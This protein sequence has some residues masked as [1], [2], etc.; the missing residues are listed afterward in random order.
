MFPI[1]VG[2]TCD[3]N[4]ET[5]A[6]IYAVVSRITE[7]VASTFL[8]AIKKTILLVSQFKWAPLYFMSNGEV[9]SSNASKAVFTHSFTVL[10]CWFHV[11]K[12]VQ[13]KYS[14]HNHSPTRVVSY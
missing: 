3:E 2:A 12:N 10:I 11:Q 1:L 7:L 9:G 13:V 4:H 6:V 5:Y 14:S 8:E